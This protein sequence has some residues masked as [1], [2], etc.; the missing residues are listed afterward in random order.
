[1]TCEHFE[2]WATIFEPPDEAELTLF[3]SPGSRCGQRWQSTAT[4]RAA[5]T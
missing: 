1:M 4:A 5:Q 2:E 3:D